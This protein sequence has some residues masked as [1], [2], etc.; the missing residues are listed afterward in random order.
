[1]LRKK[2]SMKMHNDCVKGRGEGKTDLN[3]LDRKAIQA[4][5]KKRLEGREEIS[6][7]GI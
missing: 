5:L 4:T 2:I 7:A 1:M 3:K 6:N